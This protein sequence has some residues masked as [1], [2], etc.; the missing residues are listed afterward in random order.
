M[1][2]LH[3]EIL[4]KLQEASR[5]WQDPPVD[6]IDQN[7]VWRR[8]FQLVLLKARLSRP[9]YWVIDAMDECKM[10]SDMLNILT[11]M[12]E[13]WPM[14]ILVTSRVSNDAYLSMIRTPDPRTDLV[15]DSISD[16]DSAQD[17]S[18]FVQS[19]LEHLPLPRSDMWSSRLEM[20]EYI[21]KRSAGCFL[22]AHLV[23]MELRKVT[24]LDEIKEIIESTPSTMDD[25]YQRILVDM[26]QATFGKDAAKSILIW[27]TYSFRPLTADE[28]HEAVEL[29][30]S[31]KIDKVDR[32][33]SRSCS[34]LVYIDKYDKVQLIHTT[35][36]EFL[37]RKNSNEESNALESEF[38]SE[39]MID[40]AEGHG[41]IA[42]VCL[43]YLIQR[44]KV[45]SRARRLASGLQLGSQDSPASVRTFTDYASK[46]LFQ[47]LNLVK[48]TESEI[49]VVLFKFLNSNSVL[50][51][52]EYISAHG[53][54]HTVY[55]AGKTINA[56]LARQAH[57][58]P[59]IRPPTKHLALLEKWGNDLIHIV[60]KFSRSLRASP[61][62]IHH[63]IPPFCPPDSAIH[64]Q[65]SSPFRGISVQGLSLRGWDDCLT[66]IIF[67]KGT[68]PNTVAAGPGFFAVGMMN[69]SVFVY[70]D[71]IFQEVHILDHK[72]PVWRMAF[73]ETGKY[74]ATAGAKAVR[75][76]SLQ[77]GTELTNFRIPSLCLA[78]T[79]TDNDTVLRVASKSNML[80][81]W[82][83]K[84]ASMRAEVDWS[85]DFEVD[86]PTLQLREPQMAAINGP[87]GL[88]SVIYRGE[89]IVLWDCANFGIHDIYEKETGSRKWGSNKPAG[90]STHVWALAFSGALDTNR[91]ATTHNDGDLTLYDT[92]DGRLL[93][94]ATSANANLL[95]S[96]HDGRTLGGVDSRGNL[97]LFDFETLRCLYHV[98]FD[99]PSMAK[100]LTFTADNLRCIEIRGD[101]CRVW[102]P[103]ALLRHD[104]ADEDAN[105][106]TA[107]VSTGLQEI[108]YRVAGSNS[109]GAAVKITA[110]ACAKSAPT[111]FYGMQD[112]SVHACDIAG[113]PRRQPL[114]VQ[115]AGCPIDLLY[116]DDEASVLGSAD[117]S[118]SATARKVTR[119]NKSRQRP[120][121]TTWEIGDVLIHT[122]IPG[123]V[124][125][126][127]L[128]EG[129][130]R[131]LLSSEL[132]DTLWPMPKLGEGEGESE[133]VC[134]ARVEGH[135]TPRW[136]AHPTQPYLIL[137]RED[138]FRIY[139][140]SNLECLRT[141][142]LAHHGESPFSLDRIISLQHP[143]YFATLSLARS[144]ES[145]T[146]QSL[147]QLWDVKDLGLDLD[148]TSSS[149]DTTSSP[150]T[151]SPVRDLGP[152]D[153]SGTLELVVGAYGSRLIVYTSDRWVCSV[154]LKP[155][156]ASAS[157]FP[158]PS[159]SPSSSASLSRNPT[160]RSPVPSP[161]SDQHQRQLIRHFFVPGDWI[162]G[163]RLGMGVGRAGEI[164]FVR[165]PE[166]AVI[167]R[168]L[169]VT[170]GGESFNPR[171]GSGVPVAG[172]ARVGRGPGQSPGIPVRP[173]V[174]GSV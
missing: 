24:Q 111:V 90:G 121:E 156:S 13:E 110:I 95:A 88:L 43:E 60:T 157:T 12:K 32:V 36:R 120:L 45:A 48:S 50:L 59:P 10:N 75:I 131:L 57:H 145:R 100:A 93:A 2:M 139:S 141:V 127:L 31:D 96:S 55:Q 82:D 130:K 163:N 170:E 86:F 171:R 154:D 151:I 119:H 167:K 44:S 105:G 83:M 41:R 11:R 98:Q 54:L 56:L 118:G 6:K 89:D 159:P 1:A 76:W 73:G 87:S 70:D 81:E 147:V 46:F 51:W 8:V 97:K 22:W 124:K 137:A 74:L 135:S 19:N 7:V 28:M 108:D 122:R 158:F 17:I 166:L 49:S 35:A 40:K 117:L 63:L 103:T 14:S 4:S 128:S 104:A 142:S 77:L 27:A 23:C 153:H 84:T 5:D 39:F 53:D 18:L 33:I 113:E 94:M 174:G 69:K 133:D 140:W 26:E 132:H 136:L 80:L 138:E 15:S 161:G 92:L 62:C 102:E 149:P 146:T 61:T 85:T 126:I 42:K 65:F 168:G 106:D 34:N 172:G 150:N 134:I 99:I 52:I 67:P 3:P 9:Q 101:Q 30:I 68:K 79:F 114:Y 165:G 66:T 58:L 116:F 169:E 129:H 37:G 107:F 64:Q 16:E 38:K 144:L 125:Q 155:T 21:V 20:A 164:A 123:I 29:D 78:L 71:S 148:P 47:H 173:R 162:G 109:D 115:W 112:G 72:E 91:L 25:L 143:Q 160:S 152:D